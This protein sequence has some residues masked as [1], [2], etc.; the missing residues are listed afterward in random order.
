MFA[1]DIS[2][3]ADHISGGCIIPHLYCDIGSNNS[4]DSVQGPSLQTT[5]LN[6]MVHLRHAHVHSKV[7][8]L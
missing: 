3:G 4:M 8:S 7:L 2:Y 1:T 6:T 5:G